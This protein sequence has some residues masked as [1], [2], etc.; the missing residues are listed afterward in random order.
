LTDLLWPAIRDR[1][2]QEGYQPPAELQKALQN[3]YMYGNAL[4]KSPKK[5]TEW[6]KDL[7][8]PIRDLSQNPE[9]V[10]VLWLVG[11][12]P[13][14]YPRNQ[15]VTRDF[16][17][18]LTALG[19]RWGIIGNKE[20]TIGD[21]ERLSGEE[22]LF[23][24]LIEYNIQTL[25]S[26]EYEK[27]IVTDP[28]SLNSLQNIY[29][30]Y[31][32][33]FP[34]EHYATFL[35]DRLE[36][37]KGLLVRP[38]EAVVTYHDNCCLSRRCGCYEAPRDLLRAIPGVQLVEMRR[39]REHGLC[40]GGGA[41]GMWLDGH[42]VE[43]GGHRLSDERIVEAAATGAKILAVSCPFELSRFEDA[44]KVKGLEDRIVVRDIIELLAESMDLREKTR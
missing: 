15:V 24:S 7:D 23:E 38:L 41:G 9:P 14:Y 30:K 21:C 42:I 11:D 26:Y 35:A 4:G 12:Y 29:P 34:V 8:V 10:E 36:E 43:L 22:G 16:A 6:A 25:R 37:L 28:H 44:A 27:L 31:G 40:C 33:R 20:K 19:V 17:R 18:I 32:G 1:A 5:R 13:A 39:N 2:M 3:T